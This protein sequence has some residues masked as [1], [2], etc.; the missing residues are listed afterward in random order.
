MTLDRLIEHEEN[1]SKVTWNGKP[2]LCAEEHRQLAEWLKDYKRLLEQ[3]SCEDIV[4]RECNNCAYY[5][6]GANDEACDGCFADE[7]EHPNFKPKAQHY[8]DCVDRQAVIDAFERFIHELGIEDEPYNYGEM[9]LSI[10]NVPPVTPK[11][12]ECEDC[13][14]RQAVIRL[15]EQGQIQGYEWQF[16]ELNKLPPVQPKQKMGKWIEHEC[17]ACGYG[18]MPWNDTLYC[19][20]CGAKMG[21]Q[22]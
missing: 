8:E 19:P 18:V 2:T 3:E 15:A 12:V 17:S 7:Y 4:S 9:A 1:E 14:S 16:K 10:Q 13:V 6:N 21:G 20:N 22:E 5:D 11:L